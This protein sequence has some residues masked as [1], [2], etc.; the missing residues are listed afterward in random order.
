MHGAFDVAQYVTTQVRRSDIGGVTDLVGQQRLA[1]VRDRHHPGSLVDAQS[2]VV[3]VAF[4]RFADVEPDPHQQ[5]G[6][7]VPVALSDRVLE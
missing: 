5:R 1:T 6:A 7:A 3:A 2:E 4:L